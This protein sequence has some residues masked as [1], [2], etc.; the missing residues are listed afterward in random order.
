MSARHRQH[1]RKI[2]AAK[3]AVTDWQE[4]LAAYSRVIA[5]MQ[6]SPLPTVSGAH[7]RTI[8]RECRSTLE[9]YGAELHAAVAELE[10]AVPA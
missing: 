4:D 5:H 8:V 6:Q 7:A 3:Q 2:A 1:K 9:R 10:R